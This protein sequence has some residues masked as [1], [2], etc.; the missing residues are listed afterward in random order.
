MPA[1]EN[2]GHCKG[3]GPQLDDR[4]G[5]GKAVSAREATKSGGIRSESHRIDEISIRKIFWDKCKSV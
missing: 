1:G 4:Q 2:R 3:T 5:D